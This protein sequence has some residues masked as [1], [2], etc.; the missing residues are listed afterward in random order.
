MEVLDH[1]GYTDS[2]L[3][4][5]RH[6]CSLPET[7][8]CDL[9]AS[10]VILSSKILSGVSVGEDSLVYDSSLSGRVQIGSQSIVVGVNISQSSENSVR[11]VLPDRHCLWE[12]PLVGCTR[13]ILIFCGLHDNPKIS[14]AKNGTFCGKPWKLIMHNLGIEEKDLWD[15]SIKQDKCMWNAKIFPVCPSHEMLILSMW[16]MGSIK[17]G[18]DFAHS[19]WRSSQRVSLEELHRSICFS[20]LCIDSS[21]HQADLAIGIT[22][23]CI[24]YG[25]LGRNLDQLSKEILQMTNKEGIKVCKEFLSYC[26]NFHVQNPL[27]VAQSRI[28]QVHVDL[29]RACGDE[30]AAC[31]IEQ[32]VWAAV[33]TETDEAVKYKLRGNKVFFFAVY[34]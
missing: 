10:A 17:P 23:A 18:N 1:L 26:S 32:K 33:A 28:Y 9:A 20:Q 27:V 19:T 16:L 6:M 5:R 11:Y 4:G 31:S 13:K 14:F 2:S 15:I 7:I 22:R 24:N 12:V 29:L 25:S 8:G 21:D 34:S 30:E 3:V